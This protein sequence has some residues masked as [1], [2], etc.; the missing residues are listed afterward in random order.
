MYD[1][2][3]MSGTPNPR[4]ILKID[5]VL[6]RTGLKTTGLY[7][8]IKEGTFPAQVSLGARAVGWY[9]DEVQ[10]WICDRPAVEDQRRKGGDGMVRARSHIR[11]SHT[12]PNGKDNKLPAPPESARDDAPDQ[13]P[14]RKPARAPARDVPTAR[15]NAMS[16]SP[17]SL[18]SEELKH[19]RG[20]NSRLKILLANLMLENDALRVA[21]ERRDPYCIKSECIQARGADDQPEASSG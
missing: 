1:L 8:R 15:Q 13:T 12:P 2:Y 9:E 6:R 14:R 10:D 18:E 5:E 20:E 7:E 16:A 11:G 4:T 21:I 3:R 19:M 17:D